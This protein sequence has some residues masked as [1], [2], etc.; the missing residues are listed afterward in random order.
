MGLGVLDSSVGRY[1]GILSSVLYK[2]TVSR[3][4]N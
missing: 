3:Y 1:T 4:F 2:D